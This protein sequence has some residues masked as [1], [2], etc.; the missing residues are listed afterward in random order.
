MQVNYCRENFLKIVLIRYLAY[1]TLDCARRL[2]RHF[3]LQLCSGKNYILKHK[4][5]NQQTFC[6]VIVNNLVEFSLKLVSMNSTF[7]PKNT[8]RFHQ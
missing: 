6:F 1:C 3:N 8:K 2:M 7:F 5:Q 4:A